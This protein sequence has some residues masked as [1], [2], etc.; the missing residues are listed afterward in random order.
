MDLRT[1]ISTAIL[2]IVG[3]VQDAQARVDAGTVVPESN[4]Q[5]AWVEMGLTHL[6]SVEFDILVR[7]EESSESNAKIGVVGGFFGGGVAAGSANDSGHES[8]IKLKVPVALPTGGV[9]PGR[10]NRD[11]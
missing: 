7:A 6:Q 9:L 3:G 11:D 2:D 5:K 10:R 1:F 8:R 4:L